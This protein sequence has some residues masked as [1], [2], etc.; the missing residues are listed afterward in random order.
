[1]HAIRSCSC[2]H[3]FPLRATQ[4][5][6]CSRTVVR[7]TS[8][9]YCVCFRAMRQHSSTHSPTHRT[10]PT[11]VQRTGYSCTHTTCNA[12]LAGYFDLTFICF[13]PASERTAGK[14]SD[15]YMSLPNRYTGFNLNVRQCRVCQH[16]PV[17]CKAAQQKKQSNFWKNKEDLGALPAL[18]W[19]LR[20]VS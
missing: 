17:A 8:S 6:Q 15:V 9:I 19:P 11:S 7:V 2:S 10:P 13:P 16:L 4:A 5:Q 18:L 14:R 1:M 20:N 12:A 3:A